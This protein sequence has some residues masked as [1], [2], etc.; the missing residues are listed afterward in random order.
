V[1]YRPFR[2]LP[3]PYSLRAL[4]AWSAVLKNGTGKQALAFHDLLYDKQPYED[5]ANK[6]DID[7][8]TSWAKTAGVKDDTVLNAMRKDDA[9]FVKATDLTASEANVQGTPTVVVNDQVLQG[10]PAQMA[11]QVKSLIA[12]G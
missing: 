10:S 4:T 11:D 3:D 8:L 7:K 6:P 9:A 12:K 2:L 1:E 5:D